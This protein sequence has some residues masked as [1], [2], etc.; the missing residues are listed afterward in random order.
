MEI[1]DYCILIEIEGQNKTVETRAVAFKASKAW[2][3]MDEQHRRRKKEIGF[4]VGALQKRF[5]E[6][7]FNQF[8]WTNSPIRYRLTKVRPTH[9]KGN[10]EQ[11]QAQREVKTKS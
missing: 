5:R 11:I 7:D 4:T 8:F 6:A 10:S 2:L 3:Y 1:P 9:I